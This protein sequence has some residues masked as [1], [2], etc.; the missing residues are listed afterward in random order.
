MTLRNLDTMDAKDWIILRLLKVRANERDTR[1]HPDVVK[2]LDW[3][4]RN[5]NMWE[6]AKVPETLHA[7]LKHEA[8]QDKYIY[9]QWTAPTTVDEVVPFEAL[10]TSVQQNDQ[11]YT[12]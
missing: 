9:S 1:L 8:A 12:P 10:L 5:I 3:A 2:A 4:G 11:D 6:S 7:S